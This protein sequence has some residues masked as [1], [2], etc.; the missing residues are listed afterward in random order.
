MTEP[1][2]LPPGVTDAACEGYQPL[3]T[4]GRPVENECDLCRKCAFAADDVYDGEN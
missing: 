4:C 1:S 2:N 3:C